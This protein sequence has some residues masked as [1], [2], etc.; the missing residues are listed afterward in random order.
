MHALFQDHAVLQRDRPIRVWG[1][2]EPAAQVDV[3]LGGES[4]AAT[5]DASGR[6]QISLA[7]LPAGGPYEMTARSSTGRSETIRDVLIGDV[8]MCS[9]QSNIEMPVRLAAKPDIEIGAS[10]NPRIRML[11]VHRFS[12]LSPSDGFGAP[13]EWS[14]AGPDTVKD[15]SAVCYFFGRELQKSLGVPVGLIG[16]YWGGSIAETWLSPDAARRLGYDAPLSLLARYRSDPTGVKAVWLK[17]M[18]GWWRAHDPAMSWSAPDADDSAWSEIV[19]SGWWE[20]WGVPALASFDGIVWLRKHV[21]LTEEQAKGDA[22][23]SL[24]P[25][26]DID[27]TWVN[28]TLIGT[29]E[30]W[31]AKRVYTI[32]VGT[33]HAG[34]NV[35]AVGALDLGDGGGMWGPLAEKTLRLGDGAIVPLGTPWRY[36]ISAS[37]AQTG[38]APHAPWL[39]VAGLT[40]LHN[41]MVA[42]LG[43]TALRGVVWYQG[44]SN[45]SDPREY[46][47]LLPAL[48]A[49]W[50]QGFGADLP[51]LIVQLPNYGPPASA[52]RESRW[53]E[54]REVQRLTAARDRHAGLVVTI[55]LGDRDNIHPAD[56]QEVGQRLALAARRLVYGGN[57]VDAGPTPVSAS[58]LRG[59]IAVRFAHAPLLVYGSNRP[60]GFELCDAAKICR[61]ADATLAG[62]RVLLDA[63]HM[64]RPARVRFCW[65]DSPICNLYNAA[66]LPAVPF[67]IAI[68]AARPAR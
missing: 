19:P 35:I 27:V 66:G 5:A 32:P 48:V 63:A 42:P 9:G 21:S 2:A 45:A 54:I 22:I 61:F 55:D 36:C 28:G 12:S 10:A 51:F 41:G 64:H 15:F 37:L 46:A 13:A 1:Q 38:P 56:K 62:D 26:D 29:S 50:R 67:E 60:I 33:L 68:S 47:R 6:W 49:D 43:P 39:D 31:D 7:P 23:L 30:G 14:V 34:D 40:T 17:R 44:E 59:T 57:V 65:A 24:G 16:D 3:A 4:T 58:R 18:E 8:W 25:V 53:A 11:S 52:P 20:S